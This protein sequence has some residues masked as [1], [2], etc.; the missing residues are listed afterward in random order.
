MENSE[1]PVPHLFDATRRLAHQAL[2]TGENRVK[3]FLVEAQEECEKIFRLFWMSLV[4]AVLM[5][6]AGITLT[7]LIAVA[8]WHWSPVT[9]LAILVVLYL[10]GAAFFFVRL[11][12]LRQ[13]WQSFTATLD[14]LRKDREW[15][16]K[17]P[18]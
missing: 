1:E 13:D 2:A 8:C 12:R 9:A 14:E 18:N 10:G 16:A 4:I 3:L 17:K 5:L 15:L 6:L 11:M 7:A